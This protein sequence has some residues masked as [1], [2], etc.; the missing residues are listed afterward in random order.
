M[1]FMRVLIHTGENMTL[2][3][4]PVQ[5]TQIKPR[6]TL[7]AG[8]Y[9]AP[10]LLTRPAP[11][12]SDLARAGLTVLA[13][14]PGPAC[15]AAKA[16]LTS[17]VFLRDLERKRLRICR[18]STHLGSALDLMDIEAMPPGP[19]KGRALVAN[20]ASRKLEDVKHAE[21]VRDLP[22]RQQ[23]AKQVI[24]F[25]NLL[26][27][28]LGYFPDEAAIDEKRKAIVKGLKNKYPRA[29]ELDSFAAEL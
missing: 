21:W 8:G 6:R 4:K 23:R 28:T 13:M 12:F 16:S 15:E 25:E 27:L 14:P 29:A 1:V 11:D 10:P 2:P 26:I 5:P 22:A 18:G 9:V 20:E 7:I 24:A 3:T 19:E 17:R